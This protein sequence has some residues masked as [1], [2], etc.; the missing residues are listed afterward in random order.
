MSRKKP[1]VE[2]MASKFLSKTNVNYSKNMTCHFIDNDVMM[3][4]RRSDV[5]ILQNPL[6]SFKVT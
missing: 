6:D 3:E 4:I 1:T 5:R 2:G